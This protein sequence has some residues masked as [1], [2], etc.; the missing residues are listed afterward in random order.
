MTAVA[1]LAMTL[2][3]TV[4]SVRLQQ[5]L[6]REQHLRAELQRAE[7]EARFRQARAFL[8]QSLAEAAEQRRPLSPAAPKP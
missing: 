4:Q 2:A 3:V 6:V 1:F 7:A 8:D 5:A